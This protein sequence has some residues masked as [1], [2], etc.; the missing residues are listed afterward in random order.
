MKTKFLSS[1]GVCAAALLTSL[2]SQAGFVTSNSGFTTN[3]TYGFTEA[4]LAQNAV[5]TGQ[6]AGVT[7]PSLYQWVGTTGSCTYPNIQNGCI[8]NF[9]TGGPSIT[10]FSI[11]FGSIQTQAGFNF[12]SNP[13][14]STFEA[15]LGSNSVGTSGSVATDPTSIN[16]FFGFDISSGFDSIR[17]TVGGSGGAMFLDNL[18]F[19]TSASPVP[20]PG[21]LALVGLALAVLSWRQRT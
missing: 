1:V 11:G 4:A 9:V 2:P 21:S 12:V 18:T 20:E 5:V 8:G 15:F 19:D 3:T 13:G 14:S 17:V 6:Y 10:P 16:N 7:F